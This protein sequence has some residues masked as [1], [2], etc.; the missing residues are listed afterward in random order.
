MK[1]R[2]HNGI[3]AYVPLAVR[4]SRIVT[5]LWRH[6]EAGGWLDYQRAKRLARWL[7]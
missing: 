6:T 7:P 4:E 5:W 1:P 2:R 3:D